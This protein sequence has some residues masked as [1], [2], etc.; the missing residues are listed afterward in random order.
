ML[1]IWIAYT[2]FLQVI[3]ALLLYSFPL[4]YN[5]LA[6]QLFYGEYIICNLP[7]MNHFEFLHSLGM[8]R[9]VAIII[10]DPLHWY[11]GGPVISNEILGNAGTCP[12]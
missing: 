7:Y 9:N 10:K 3:R 2:G 12:Q 8:Q 5:P 6:M 4:W 11:C 1:R